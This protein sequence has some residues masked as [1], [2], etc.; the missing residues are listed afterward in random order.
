M[1][2]DYAINEKIFHWQSQNLSKPE[3][4][5]GLSYITHQK[6]DKTTIVLFIREKNTDQF[7]NTMGYI[8]LGIVNYKDHYGSKP[9]NINWELKESMP[10]YLWKDSAKLA[11]A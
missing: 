9:M 3:I 11:V 8:F 6:N 10:P 1:Y 2:N 7:K 4:G 5:K